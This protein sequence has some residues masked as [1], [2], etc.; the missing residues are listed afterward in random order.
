[1]WHKK[2]LREDCW[3]SRQNVHAQHKGNLSN[4]WEGSISH[5]VEYKVINSPLLKV[6][7]AQAA[8]VNSVAVVIQTLDGHWT[9]WP[10]RTLSIVRF[11]KCVNVSVIVNCNRVWRFFASKGPYSCPLKSLDE[12]PNI[13]AVGSIY[14]IMMPNHQGNI[15]LPFHQMDMFA[16]WNCSTF[17]PV[18]LCLPIALFVL[19][20][21]HSTSSSYT[22]IISQQLK[23][24]RGN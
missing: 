24:L 21:C 3:L 20:G 13:Q 19:N 23:I 18:R 8:Y 11:Y 1:M 22:S 5:V 7:W 9:R 6:M 2:G 17:S 10:L 12:C 16:P 4:Y 14:Y 15:F